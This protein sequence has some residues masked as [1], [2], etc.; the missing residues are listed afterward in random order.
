VLKKL[1]RDETHWPWAE[2]AVRMLMWHFADLRVI[3]RLG[4][5]ADYTCSRGAV[6]LAAEQ[7]LADIAVFEAQ[8]GK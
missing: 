6:P 4:E 2:K 7:A 3:D 5:A 8:R 1:V